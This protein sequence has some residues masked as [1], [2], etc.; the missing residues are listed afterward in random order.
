MSGEPLTSTEGLAPGDVVMVAVELRDKTTGNPYWWKRFCCVVDKPH[1]R[2]FVTLLTLKM[3]PEERDL[4]EV[5]VTKDVVTKLPE[6]QWPQ[7]VIAMRMKLIM[8][9]VIKLGSV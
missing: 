4:R 9:R 3:R 2:R 6:E 5:D 1:N 8:Q 7:G